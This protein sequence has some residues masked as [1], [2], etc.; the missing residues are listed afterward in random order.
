[1][2][3]FWSLTMLALAAASVQA[4]D[5]EP[6]VMKINGTPV[7]RSEF[8]YFYTK[9]NQQELAEEKSFDEYVDLFINYKLKVA[10]A[11]SRGID[12][13][14]AY[15]NELAGYR[16]QLAEP[17]LQ[18][19]GWQDSMVVEYLNRCKEQV[20]ASH[21]LVTLDPN[22]TPEQVRAAEQKIAECK[23]Q[24]EAGAS[25]DSL[26]LAVSE[27]PSVRQNRGHLGYFSAGRMV[28]SFE[29]AAY[30]TP[31]GG[32]ST[33]RSRFGIHLIRVN[34]HRTMQGEVHIAH[35]M[36]AFM[37]P[38]V[39]ARREAKNSIDSLYTLVQHGEDFAT[40]ARQYSDDKQTAPDGGE[41]PWLNASAP[42][43]QEW[44]D[45][46]FALQKE[47]DVTAPFQTAYGWHML[48][49]L[50][51]RENSDPTEEELTM[52]KE[53][54]GSNPERMEV[55][56]QRFVEHLRATY[57]PQVQ[58]KVRAQVVTLAADTTLS[59]EAFC[60]ALRDIK[61]PLVTL[62]QEK[63]TAAGLA[64]YIEGNGVDPN[65]MDVDATL[66]AWVDHE[67]L[68]V[69]DA[70]LEDKYADFRNLYNEYHDGILLFD[71]ASTE[72][73]DKAASDSV[74]LADFFRRNRSRYAWDVPRFKGA[75]VE[76]AEN[77]ALVSTLCDIYKETDN[78]AVKASQRIRAEVLTD[79]TLVPNLKTPPF[80]IVNGIFQRGD[81]E[82][83]DMQ[84]F[85]IRETCS[86]RQDMPVVM[87]F[88][89]ILPDGPECVD[90]VRGQ[91]V[92]DYQVELEERW[93]A[94]LRA[95][96]KVEVDR[97]VLNQIQAEEQQ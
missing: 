93:V 13:T 84:Q 30:R 43:P 65:G 20:D 89:K 56:K 25:F 32:L 19:P 34:D 18:E 75:F 7:Y 67:L 44:L 79:S 52:L 50:G 24:I 55:A 6:I 40:L 59:R 51:K 37:M 90:D 92:A 72:V 16:A 60:A 23:A 46:A 2:K 5:S 88:G 73:W 26:A 42:F 21:I 53:R 94:Q 81:N 33:C 10:E 45:A 58:S 80:H 11:L 39:A 36:K 12:T 61:K 85:K 87:T 86:P 62:T 3:P 76:C 74:G 96:Y 29:D 64:D 71:V 83:V 54:I 22:A 57:R 77:E 17:Y 78:D 35:I 28:Y 49:L 1:M 47:G 38:G 27:D 66:Q 14:A 91:V 95:K 69:E 41:Y 31:V 63:L 97:K 8:E 4:K 48:R 68:T 82:A 15:V 70:H 9:N